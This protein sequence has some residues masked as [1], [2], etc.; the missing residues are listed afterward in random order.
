MT[1]T[2]NPPLTVSV[3]YAAI[4]E[5]DGT[6]L[7]PIVSSGTEGPYSYQWY[8]SD[9]I[10]LISTSL[11]ITVSPDTTTNYIIVASDNCSLNDTASVLV[12]VIKLADV[13]FYS[14][15]NTGCTITFTDTSKG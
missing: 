2:V 6:V 13:N 7:N 11:S 9:T 4:C 1:V 8:E 12:A 5:G 15:N 14:D 3:T 10:T